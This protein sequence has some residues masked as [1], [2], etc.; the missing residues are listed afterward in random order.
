MKKIYTVL[1]LAG[2]LLSV[3]GGVFA[4]TKLV[5]L[6]ERSESIIRLDNPSATL[7]EEQRVI[8]LQQGVNK[9]D[10]SWAGVSIEPDSIR[11]EVLNAPQDVKLL[12]VSYPPAENALV[13]EITSK[14]PRQQTVRVSYLLSNIDSIFAYRLCADKDEKTVKADQYLILRNFSGEDFKDAKIQA[15]NNISSTQSIA[16]YQTKQILAQNWDGVK[17]TKN[18]K[19]DSRQQAWDPDRVDTNINI[20]VEYEIENTAPFNTSNSALPEGK[21]RIYQ[22]DGTGSTI[23]LGEDD[24][25]RILPGKKMKLYVGDSRDIVVKQLKT[26]SKKTNE[27]TNKNGRTVLFDINETIKLTAKNHKNTPAVLTITQHIDGQW[28]MLKCNM[29]YELKQ[30]GTLEFR[31]ELGAGEEKNLNM[32]YIRKNLR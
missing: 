8:T 30:L 2:M 5:A 25:K 14:A 9:V 12:S 31:M 26:E 15:V 17:I 13:W 6:P 28:E 18:W 4:R 24:T 19:W 32:R 22:Q 1:I 23:F 7:I 29:E 21:V 27:R 3:S 11:L 10:F 20:P 16:N